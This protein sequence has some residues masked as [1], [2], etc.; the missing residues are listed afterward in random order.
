M[1]QYSLEEFYN[2]EGA[3]VDIVF[4]HGLRR[5]RTKTWEKDGVVWP[6]DLLKDDIKKSRIFSW[7]YDSSVF[8][9]DTAEDQMHGTSFKGAKIAG[10]GEVVRRIFDLVEKTDA[11]AL[12]NLE[13]NSQGLKALR[14]G[15]PEVIRKRNQPNSTEKV[16]VAFFF[17]RKATYGVDI[18]KKDDAAYLGLGEIIPMNSN[19]RDICTFD[20][21]T[22]EGYKKIKAEIQQ[23]VAV[24]GK[25]K[26]AHY[27]KPRRLHQLATFDNAS[28]GAWGSLILMFKIPKSQIE[29]LG[30]II[31]IL[32]IGINT[33]TQQ[34]IK[35]YTCDLPSPGREAIIPVAKYV[36]IRNN[37]DASVLDSAGS[38][39]LD[40]LAIPNVS[41]EVPTTCLTGNCTFA[42][43][44]GHRLYHSAGI[45]HR[46]WNSAAD[47][48]DRFANSTAWSELPNGMVVGGVT[49]TVINM[50]TSASL[51]WPT[52]R[53]GYSTSI[54]L[55]SGTNMTIPC[56]ERERE[57]GLLAQNNNINQRLKTT[58]A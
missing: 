30:A 31:T 33:F 19:H 4:V 29:L 53:E 1:A 58:M 25:P 2:G 28:R 26:A 56:R 43:N 37:L 42:D 40:S 36:G 22:D 34:S 15:F 54:M 44:S 20:A 47:F 12:K 46:C 48:K 45:C 52:G 32:W 23:F 57:Q 9:S 5:H 55:A 41:A 6:K 16:A 24:Q 10:W 49:P 14:D 27:R 50:S 35:T 3:E 39:G 11:N 7:G 21:A 51:S 13:P 18:V 17:E 38:T 8:H